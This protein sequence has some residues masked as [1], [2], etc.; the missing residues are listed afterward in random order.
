M[1]QCCKLSL[2]TLYG[3]ISECLTE[4]SYMEPMFICMKVLLGS[5]MQWLYCVRYMLCVIEY[6][7]VLQICQGNQFRLHLCNISQTATAYR[8]LQIYH[9]RL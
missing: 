5:E 7:I 3:T 9:C 6:E 2:I 8:V 1:K 4:G